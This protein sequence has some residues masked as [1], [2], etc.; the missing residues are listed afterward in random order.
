MNDVSKRFCEST[1]CSMQKAKPQCC[2]K[3]GGYLP[4]NKNKL[5]P[6]IEAATRSVARK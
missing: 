2:E 3:R 6:R 5:P 1:T 4:V